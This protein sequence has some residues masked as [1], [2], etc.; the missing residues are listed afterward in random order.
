LLSEAFHYSPSYL[1]RIF[2]SEKGI[3]INSYL[4][5]VRIEYAVQ[6]LRTTNMTVKEIALRSGYINISHFNR[7]FKKTV[8]VAPTYIKNSGVDL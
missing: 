5:K 4:N 6:L 8:G 7:I 1:S 3:T 2:H